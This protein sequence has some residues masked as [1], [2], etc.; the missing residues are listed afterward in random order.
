MSETS[1]SNTVPPQNVALGLLYNSINPNAGQSNQSTNPAAATPV[2][3]QG[4]G[5]ETNT[6]ATSSHKKADPNAIVTAS[7]NEMLRNE[8]SLPPTESSTHKSEINQNIAKKHEQL[9]RNFIANQG[10]EGAQP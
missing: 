9:S 4:K 2:P 3:S 1:I 6:G 10:L 7:A 5:I 8:G